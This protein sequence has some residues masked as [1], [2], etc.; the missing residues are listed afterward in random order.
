M[1]AEGDLDVRGTLAVSREAPVGLRSIRLSFELDTD[2]SDAE[3]AALLSRTERYCVVYQTIAH[4]VQVSAS[5]RRT[6]TRQAS[7]G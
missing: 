7:G 1:R 3:I 4:P 5:A 2:A 6:G